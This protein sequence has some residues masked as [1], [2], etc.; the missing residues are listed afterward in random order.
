MSKA[1]SDE[2]CTACCYMHLFISHRQNLLALRLHE[3]SSDCVAPVPWQGY[4]AEHLLSM[5]T[6]CRG[7]C[8]MQ[9]LLV[10]TT[11]PS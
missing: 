11:G 6:A 2:R 4:G 5:G 10:M 7:C 3:D 1:L 8:N 9:L